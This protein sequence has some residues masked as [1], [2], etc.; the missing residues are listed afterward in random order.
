MSCTGQNMQ[1]VLVED[2]FSALDERTCSRNETES[3]ANMAAGL[4]L[5][6]KVLFRRHAVALN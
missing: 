1:L 6:I 2:L 3:A 5:I 4:A